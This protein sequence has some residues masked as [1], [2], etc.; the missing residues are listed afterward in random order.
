[1]QRG[2][3]IQLRQCLAQSLA[4][5]VS[6]LMSDYLCFL[7]SLLGC[8]YVVVPCSVITAVCNHSSSE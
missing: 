2:G 6:K 7:N 4:E 5:C 1:M 3:E 8:C